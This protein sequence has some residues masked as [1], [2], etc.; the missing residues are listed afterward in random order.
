MNAREWKVGELARKTGLTVRTL[1]HYDRIGLFSPSR[2][3]ES[4]HRLYSLEDVGKL[5]QIVS[6]KQLGFALDEIKRMLS[7]PEYRPEDML[8][9][10]LSRLNERIRMLE[11]LR[12]RVQELADLLG[13]GRS[14]PGERL[15]TAIQM[16]R[17]TESKHYDEAQAAAIRRKMKRTTAR[18]LARSDEEGRALIAEF[19]DALTSGMPPD[20]P[21]VAALAARWKSAMERFVSDDSWVRSAERYYEDHPEDAIPYGIDGEL[22]AYI[23]QA[24]AML[25]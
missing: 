15:L 17:M 3:T 4:G 11:T 18:E 19:R 23:K 16:M 21:R 7:S 5:Q 2:T 14:V 10:Q 12:D 6:L 22:Y 25:R 1:H 8:A 13:S 20:D 9:L 24:V